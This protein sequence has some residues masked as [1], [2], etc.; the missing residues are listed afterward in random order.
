MAAVAVA[1][2]LAGGLVFARR[3]PRAVWL[4]A[5]T[6][7]LA[8]APFGDLPL[9]VYVLVAGHAFCAGRWAGLGQGLF[10][11]AVLVAAL[12]LATALAGGYGIVLALLLPAA[13][14]AAG[15]VVAGRDELV[16][17][18]DLRARDLEAERE[19][20][21]ALSVSYE[22][23]RIA[24]ELH[25]IVAHALSVM[26]V[27]AGAG[28]RMVGREPA[29][30][31]GTLGTIASAA[32]EAERDLGRLIALLSDEPGAPAP[33]LALVEQ[34]VGHAAA[35]GVPVALRVEG[36]PEDVPPP[37]AQLGYRL[38]QEGL[39]NALRHAPG[40]SVQVVLR[41]TGGT[42]GVEVA[43]ASAPPSDAPPIAGTGTGLRGLRERVLARG[44]EMRAAPTPAGG[45]QLTARVP[46]DSGRAS[47]APSSEP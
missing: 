16:G 17:R 22:R 33:D 14:W 19:A 21:A 23:A 35:S 3:Y 6:V 32:R 4:V 15:R 42:M 45:W 18:L 34:L 39:T 12:E 13:G 40:A 38:V 44:G 11:T 9:F 2:V 30:V 37:V 24:A 8:A 29:A 43:N 5:V 41:V 47:G 31:T 25:D 1:V 28:Q 36:R 7:L 27:Q 26:V 46:L 10:R 20:H